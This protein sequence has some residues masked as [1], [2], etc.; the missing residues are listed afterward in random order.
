MTE[1]ILSQVQAAE[2]GFL[3]KVHGVTLRG[4]VRSCE[5]C[6]ARIVEPLLFRIKRFQLCW[7]G[8]VSRM[9]HERLTRQVLLAK[10]TGK[11]PRGRQRTRC[12]DCIS[13]LCLVPSWCG[14]SKITW[15]YCWPW[16]TPSPPGAATPTT[17]L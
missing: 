11:H 15:N 1:R 2:M 7:F 5:I 3:R 10:P 6:R 17:L 12:S 8:H 13:D 9:P 14:A 16:G 4:Q